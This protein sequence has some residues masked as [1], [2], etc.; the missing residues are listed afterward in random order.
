MSE[1]V[2]QESL[3]VP[4]GS[5]V[6]LHLRRLWNE[7]SPNGAPILMLHGAAEDGYIFYSQH[8]RG[9]AC[10]LARHGYQVFVADMR[11]K[12]KSWPAI[13]QN[14]DFGFHELVTEDIPALAA[15]ISRICDGQEQTW[16]THS[17]GG[18]LA[19]ACLVRQPARALGVK[20]LVHFA[21]RRVVHAQGLRRRLLV[22]LLWNR[23][24]RLAVAYEGY[25]PAPALGIGTARETA[26]CF[27][28]ALAWSRSAQWLDTEDGF[29]YG[30]ALKSRGWLRS[31]YFASL[32]DRAFGHPE[33]VRDFM[34][35][36]GRHDG[37]LL[38]LGKAGGNLHDYSHVGMLLHPDAE[39]DHFV[40][41][42]E[43]LREGE[44]AVRQRESAVQS[45]PGS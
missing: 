6:Q 41:L 22:D 14:S 18:A 19:A 26:R 42:L 10:F 40:Q 7:S 43:W 11:G 25:L 2:S 16:V 5:N 32:T 33:D 36:L 31:L 1:V 15:R 38:T 17:L 28:D 44:A 8:G 24:G 35:E 9:L 4:V 3:M 30:A 12:G 27:R 45:Q 20:Q 39:I 29:D 23:I 21:A 37:R 34:H 13:N